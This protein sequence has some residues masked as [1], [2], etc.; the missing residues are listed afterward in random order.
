MLNTPQL[1][2][3]YA[4]KAMINFLKRLPPGQRVGLFVLNDHPRLVQAFTSSSDAL[5]AAGKSLGAGCPATG[6]GGHS[7]LSDPITRAL[8]ETFGASRDNLTSPSDSLGPRDVAR[9]IVFGN[10]CGQSFPSHAG[11]VERTGASGCRLLGPKEPDLAVSEIS[12][13]DWM[14]VCHQQSR[15]LSGALLPEVWLRACVIGSDNA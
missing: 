15:G 5:I 6:A 14:G 12:L 3:I 11:H 1:E 10:Y 2:Q 13:Y 4:R 7:A 8:S 9:G